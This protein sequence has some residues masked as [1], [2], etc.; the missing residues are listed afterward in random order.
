MVGTTRGSAMPLVR[1][2]SAGMPSA[3]S[4]MWA[5]VS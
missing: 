4:V 5:P 2:R 1:L 3:V